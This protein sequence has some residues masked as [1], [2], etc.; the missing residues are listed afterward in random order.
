MNSNK[1]E[2]E[3]ENKELNSQNINSYIKNNEDNLSKNK[4]EIDPN[5]I[6]KL[7]ETIN[8]SLKRSSFK[9]LY[10]YYI[11][12]VIIEN[13][14]IGIKYII[15]ICKKYSFAQLKRNLYNYKIFNSLE[16]LIFPFRN[17]ILKEFLIKL[18][19]FSEKKEILYNSD[20]EPKNE[21]KSDNNKNLDLSD[22]VLE[23]KNNN[24]NENNDSLSEL[25]KN[26]PNTINSNE[27]EN[28]KDKNN[29]NIEI[30]ETNNNIIKDEQPY[31]KIEISS[32]DENINNDSNK[33]SKYNLKKL[34]LDKLTE[35]IL[36]NILS[37]ELTSK[38]V[39][40]I[41]KKKFKFK[42]KL[43][44][45]KGNSSSNSTDNIN[46][47][48]KLS[49]LSN[50][51]KLS[52][53]DDTLS[54]LNDSIMDAF[55]Q[56]SYFF[57]T[58]IDKKKFLLIKFYQRKI[59]PKLID[60]IKQEIIKKYDRIYK[61]ISQPY[62][63]NS[64]ELM[65]SLILQ[66][67]DM[68]KDN[69][70]I[71][72]YNESI[73]D[74]IDKEGL[75][76]QFEP[77][78]IKL[79]NQ[80]QKNEN[81]K[82]NKT[83]E[84]N[85]EYLKYDFYMN[86]CLIDCA[87]ELINCE[88]KY[89]ENGNPL[90]WSSRT[91]ELEFKYPEKDPT[92]LVNFVVRNIFKFLKQKNGLIC[93]NYENIPGEIISSEREKRL[94]NTIKTELEDGDYLWRNLEMEETQLKV[95]VSDCIVEQLYNEVIEILEHVQL[96]RTRGELY[97]YRSIYACEEMPKLSFQQTTTTENADNDENNDSNILFNNV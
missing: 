64:K 21:E 33:E 78:N 68:L 79:R 30:K 70:K 49:D 72:T 89:G 48:N 55:T 56:K 71:Q 75:L 19:Q 50:L 11:K 7:I 85:T 88:R 3:V 90:I 66:D 6:I 84:L 44:N 22:V 95:E 25:Y 63:N 35:E 81:K 36:Q 29:I 23:E 38:D 65:I 4:K 77:I 93:D 10:K 43:K 31:T 34:N 96:S 14:F 39:K 13:Y 40:I 45:T 92:K 59:A 73:A 12:I 8:Y 16:N 37:S 27:N 57:K 53:N 54:S 74:I 62:E 91:R 94:I 76:K 61:N 97:H 69:F 26:C 87:I 9:K 5:K 18:K 86:K 83:S 80:W 82:D 17:I 46:T 15:A 42:T 52:L 1:E 32:I 58:I 24:N 28:N 67:P 2:N 51:S 20:E 41:P 60:L 47:E